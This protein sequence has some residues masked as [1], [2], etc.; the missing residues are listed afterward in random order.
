MSTAKYF[1]FF[2]AA[3]ILG[4]ALFLLSTFT[5]GQTDQNTTPNFEIRYNTNVRLPKLKSAF[6]RHVK[7][8]GL[9]IQATK[10]VPD[11]KLIHAADIAADFL[12]NDRDGKPD[13]PTINDEL[14]KNRSA[15]VM[16]YNELELEKLHDKFR[17]LFDNYALQGLF[18]TETLPSGGPH[19]PASPKFDA[20]IEE[21]LHII[22][23]VGYARVYPE[24]FG[25]KKGSE[26]T[27]AMDKARG[28][29]F[30][31]V[32]GKYPSG[33]WYSY[34]DKTCD[35]ECQATEYIYWALTSLMNGQNFKMR[36]QNIRHEWKLNTPEKLRAK[37]KNIVNILTNKKYILP[38]RLPDGKYRNNRKQASLK[39]NIIEAEEKLIL[40]I[41][42]STA[43]AI[44]LETSKDLLSWKTNKSIP[45]YTGSLNLPIKIHSE[46]KQFF[47]LQI[48]D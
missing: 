9:F 5:Y 21:I 44:I 40:T 46:Q 13:N 42:L 12:D 18:A 23:S 17:E 4:A 22:T 36:E 24:V 34:D 47:R 35:Y 28:G 37:D 33:A 29:H 3:A 45:A 30:R 48:L 14:W 15:I 20:S 19:N 39:L 26:L 11:N 16:G 1:S 8:F 43:S 38:L 2:R 27:N 41:A 6:P 32:P 7:V 31:T 10:Q 25:E